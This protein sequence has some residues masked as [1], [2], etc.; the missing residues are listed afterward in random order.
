MVPVTSQDIG[1]KPSRSYSSGVIGEPPV[2][3]LA[4]PG[5]TRSE[6][7]ASSLR[8]RSVPLHI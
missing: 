6:V 8:A 3:P 7:T 5:A 4:S 1:N 2:K